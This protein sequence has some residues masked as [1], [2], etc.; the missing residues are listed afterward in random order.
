MGCF[1]KVVTGVLVAAV[2]AVAVV[3]WFFTN[4]FSGPCG[5][6][7][8]AVAERQNAIDFNARRDTQLAEDWISEEEYAELLKEV[9]PEP[10]EPE[11]GC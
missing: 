7:R 1:G 6:Y 10:V 9:P 8:R 5:E 4:V 3:A 2:L 11:G